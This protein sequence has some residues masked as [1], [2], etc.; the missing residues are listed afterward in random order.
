[1]RAGGLV[2]CCGDPPTHVDGVPSDRAS[3]MAQQAGWKRVEAVDVPALLLASADDRFAIKRD[4]GEEGIL[5][6]HRRQIQDGQFLFLV[7]TSIES[8]SAGTV[9]SDL[10][11]VKQWDL[12]TGRVEPYP[13]ERTDEGIKARFD[14]PPSGSLLLFLSNKRVKPPK[15]PDVTTTVCAAQPGPTE[16]R[17]LSPNVLTLD[18]VDINAGGKTHKNV[19]FYRANQFAFQANGMDR[20]PWDSAVQFKDELITKKFKPDSGFT[21]RYKFIIEES[22]PANLAIVIER[23]DLYKIACNGRRV[24]AKKGDWWLDKA[25]GR[26]DIS[27]AAQVGQNI[28]TIEAQPFT[29]Y[30]ELE[31]AY[32]LGDFT[33]KPATKG[34]VIAPD[35]PLKILEAQGSAR[36]GWRQ[37]GHPFYA[38]G[39]SYRRQF[40]VVKRKGSYIVSLPD[41]RGSVARVEVNGKPAGH[42]VSPPWECD[43]TKRIKRGRNEIDVVVIGTLKNTLGP[44]HNG[45]GLGSAWPGMFQ[46]GPA[47]GPPP[48][49][50]YAGVEYGLFKPFV[51]EQKTEN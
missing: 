13:F 25:F 29:I 50:D 37:Q 15:Q 44:H 6:H 1:V 5:F 23:A 7:N 47:T 16:V 24:T 33:V 11:G 10:N 9:L 19:Y 14:L 34:F 27:A 28:V 3:A 30:H 43:V 46:K 12:N 22:V 36:P 38:A 40:E 8:P 35:K 42:I 20:N 18:Y 26:I 41:W 32:V 39:V 51:L 31:P 45:P 17:R 21:A 2:L 48:G 49:R 4:E